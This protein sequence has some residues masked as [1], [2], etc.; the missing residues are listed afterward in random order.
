MQADATKPGPLTYD[1]LLQQNHELQQDLD[2]MSTREKYIWTTLVET[3]RKLQLSS[4]S[5]KAAV[6]SLLNYDI[7]WDEANQHEFLSTISTSIDQVSDLVKL[8]A[9]ES[10]LEAGVLELKCEPHFLQEILS[11]VR[12]NLSRQD[13]PVEVSVLLPEDGKLIE[14]DY[15]YLTLALEMLIHVLVS[16]S[17]QGRIPVI[18]EEIETN[19][20][21]TLKGMDAVIDLIR[22]MLYCKTQP[23][24]LGLLS[25]ENIL[26]LQIACEILHLQKVEFEFAEDKTLM[27]LII[28]VYSK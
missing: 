15:A 27:K 20:T 18:A 9:L 26:K 14:V 24:T 12:V 3:S 2:Q 6:S 1:E 8:V 5:I 19:W 21:V 10:R 4:A 17:V 13:P 11:V 16:G 7:F 28:P 23:D 25:A 22:T